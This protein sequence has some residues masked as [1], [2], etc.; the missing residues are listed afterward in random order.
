MEFTIHLKRELLPKNLR[1]KITKN[2]LSISAGKDFL[3]IEAVVIN[4]GWFNQV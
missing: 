1:V 3:K 2:L 4:R